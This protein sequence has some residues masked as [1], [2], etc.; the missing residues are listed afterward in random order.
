ML[1]NRPY[2]IR[3]FWNDENTNHD[4]FGCAGK[5]VILNLCSSMLQPEGRANILCSS[6]QAGPWYSVLS[7]DVEEDERTSGSGSDSE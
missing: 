3:C 6:L 4:I 1:I 5:K 7:K 2:N